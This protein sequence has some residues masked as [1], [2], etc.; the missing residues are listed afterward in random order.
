PK[1]HANLIV[2]TVDE[3]VHKTI[4]VLS[5]EG[6]GTIVGGM[7]FVEANG[8]YS[9]SAVF[10]RGSVNPYITEFRIIDVESSPVVE[11]YFGANFATCAH[12]EQ[13]AY[14]IQEED[15]LERKTKR[16]K[17][18]EALWYSG[19]HDADTMIRNLHWSQN[20]QRLA[21]TEESETDTDFVILHGTTVEI[22]R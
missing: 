15:S 5:T 4:P 19:P 21:F 13:V 2:I 8:W 11:G 6:D 17:V 16:I 18:N 14:V 9:H 7:R 22:R 3:G 10:A 12:K 1:T 20:C